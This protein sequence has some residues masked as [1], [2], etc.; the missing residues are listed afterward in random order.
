MPSF[1]EMKA[2]I[3]SFVSSKSLN[4]YIVNVQ[5]YF[6]NLCLLNILVQTALNKF[7]I[8]IPRCLDTSNLIGDTLC[9]LFEK[10][11]KIASIF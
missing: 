4:K 5:E 7:T 3:F 2:T 11:N 1:T 9:H 6:A 10:V 8:S